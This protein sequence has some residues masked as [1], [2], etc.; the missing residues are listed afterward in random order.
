MQL[1]QRQRLLLGGIQT[2]KLFVCN[3]L[4]VTD[5]PDNL[6]KRSN[7]IAAI[8]V[9]DTVN[10]VTICIKV[11]GKDRIPDNDEESEVLTFLILSTLLSNFLTVSILFQRLF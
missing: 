10:P 7:S 8:M 11:S 2:L 5:L 4:K 3:C 9:L 6:V 1:E